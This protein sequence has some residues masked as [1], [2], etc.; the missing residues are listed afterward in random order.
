MQQFEPVV[1]ARI[2]SVIR[3]CGQQAKQMAAAGLE[4]DLKAPGDFVTQV[5]RLLDQQLSAE[6]FSLFPADGLITE[7]NSASVQRFLESHER[8]WCIDPIDGTKDFIETG[9]DYAVMVGLLEGHQPIGG[10]VY[11]PEADHLWFG[12]PAWGLWQ[13]SSDGPVEACMAQSVALG[14]RVIIGA[15][16]QKNYGLTVAQA[17]PEIDLWG[18]PGS[19]G[20]KII[21]VILGKAGLLVYFNGRVKL[22]DTVGPLALAQAAGLVCCDLAGDPIGYSA[23]RINPA[24]LAHQQPIILG[25]PNYV[26]AYRDRLQAALAGLYSQ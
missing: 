24:T 18:R 10:W 17:I 13:Q 4:V 8:F 15:N 21:D 26:E 2:R 1:E 16:D 5:D 3:A 7:E 9:K 22:W 25:W 19:F 23:D 12:G 11:E 20:L 14:G 6:F